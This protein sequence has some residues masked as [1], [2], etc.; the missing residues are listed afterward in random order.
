MNEHSFH[1][2]SFS[3]RLHDSALSE[4]RHSLLMW[5]LEVCSCYGSAM[6]DQN[7]KNPFVGISDEERRIMGRL[8]RMRPEPHQEAPKPTGTQADAQR[9]RRQRE[10]E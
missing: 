9:R 5:R 2:P 1:C 7:T 10:R 3:D 6:S 8:L 4:A